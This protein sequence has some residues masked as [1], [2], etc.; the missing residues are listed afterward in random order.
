M[1]RITLLV[2]I[3]NREEGVCARKQKLL[4]QQFATVKM[5]IIM[6]YAFHCYNFYRFQ[7]L[8]NIILYIEIHLQ[9]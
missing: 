5:Y 6:P 1:Q 8:K 4:L 9:F 2:K 3:N 7:G